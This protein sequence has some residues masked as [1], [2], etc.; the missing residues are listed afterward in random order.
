MGSRIE[1]IVLSGLRWNPF[2]TR[3]CGCVRVG[4]LP[5]EAELIHAAIIAWS[6]LRN[7][8]TTWDP[9][10]GIPRNSEHKKNGR[11]G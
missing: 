6:R 8:S 3:L 4:D 1:S 5:R 9:S 2:V 11:T 7:V 10:R